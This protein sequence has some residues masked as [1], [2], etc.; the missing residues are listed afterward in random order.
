MN[1]LKK[2][3]LTALATSLIASTA[4]YAGEM[5][6]SGSASLNY[7][8][9]SNKSDT[10]P[11]SMGNS[12]NFT[13]GGD[14]DNGMS[15]SVKYEIDGGYTPYDDYSLTL[16]TNGMGA[17]TFSGQSVNAGGIAKV[18]D[19]VPNAYTPVYESTDADDNG[20]GTSTQSSTTGMF[21]Y[22][23]SDGGLMLS[24]G[25]QPNP[26]AAADPETSYAVSYD[27]LM[28]GLT[29]VAG[30]LDDGN[31]SENTTIGAKYTVGAI[32]AAYQKTDIEL[33]AV[34]GN[35]EEGK[36]YGVSFAVNENLTIAAG[37]QETEFKAANTVAEEN[38]G[39]SASYTMGSMTIGA[40]F[41]KVENAAG[42]GSAKDIEAT[43]LNVAF[44]F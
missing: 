7:S 42:S 30:F 32:T 14:L 26:A 10:N 27:G 24:V 22:T 11:F 18:N 16:D 1:N 6:V 21:G 28:D 3:G 12:L 23:Y 44:A 9:I 29:L 31:Y 38:T 2:V 33:D 8:G 19:I 39:W 15:V 5:S 41:N 36:H 4:S 25:Y 13:G 20:L 35:D 17:L 43:I 34:G 40:A 37:R